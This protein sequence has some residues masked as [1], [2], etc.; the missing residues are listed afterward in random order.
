MWPLLTGNA[1]LMDSADLNGAFVPAFVPWWTE[2]R[3]DRFICVG[4]GGS[5]L[6]V[7]LDNM[8]ERDINPKWDVWIYLCW[9]NRKQSISSSLFVIVILLI[10]PEVGVSSSSSCFIH[11]NLHWCHG[12][13]RSLL[14][15]D[16]VKLISRQCT[17]TCRVFWTTGDP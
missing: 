9:K 2:A 5:V 16:F 1:P 13:D 6:R 15:T 4:S 17:C 14:S 7:P 3:Q 12:E 10:S 8:M 11:L